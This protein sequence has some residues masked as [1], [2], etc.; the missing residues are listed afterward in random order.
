MIKENI[1][2]IEVKENDRSIELMGSAN[3]GAFD[4]CGLLSGRLALTLS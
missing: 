2:D 4:R 3:F 1:G